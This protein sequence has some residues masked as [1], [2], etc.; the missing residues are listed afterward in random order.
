MSKKKKMK[1][2]YS[3]KL[4]KK[5]ISM[6]SDPQ[7]QFLRRW[8]GGKEYT[9]KASCRHVTPLPLKTPIFWKSQSGSEDYSS[10]L[11]LLLTSYHSR[12][13]V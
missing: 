7:S 12:P 4:I 8:A 11:R 5:S 9:V 10:S 6:P 3:A 13:A 1:H 2:M